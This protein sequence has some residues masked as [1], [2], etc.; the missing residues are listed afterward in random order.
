MP[1][2]HIIDIPDFSLVIMIGAAGAGKSSFAARHFAATEIIS[3]DTYRGIVSDDESNQEASR[4]AFELVHDIAAKRLKRRKLAVIDA[5]N[6][7]ADDRDALIDLAVK[8]HAPPV[9]LVINP[10]PETCFAQNAARTKRRV[11]DDVIAAQLQSLRGSLS[12]LDTEGFRVVHK[13]MSVSEI[14]N[15]DIKRIPVLADKRHLAGPFDIIGDVHGCCDELIALMSKLGYTV[16]MTKEGEVWKIVTQTPPGRTLVF[17]GDLVDRG[18]DTP[19]VLR[20]AMHMV[21]CGQALCVPGNHD[22][23]L[24]RWLRGNDV[25][26]THGLDKSATQ[27]ANEPD[28]WRPK[29]EK[30]V[31]DLPSHLWLDEGRLAVAHAGIKASLIGRVSRR[32]YMFCLYGE[33]S[34]ETDEFGLPIRYNWAAEYSGDTAIVYGHTPVP[35]ANWLNNTM[36][37]DT[38]CCFGGKLTALRW[39][40][41]E[42]VSV[43]A[44]AVY[45]EPIRPFGHPPAR[46]KAS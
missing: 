32:V 9:A 6:V 1:D 44:Q 41:K 33:T 15:T 37:L 35:E 36:C 7:R 5:T 23:K 12:Q 34:G 18:P 10:G 31:A 26:L 28:E 13:L 14:D 20:L 8:H 43:P 19:G 42:V 17:V 29:I 39:P 27:L 25:T 24:M 4:D 30:F 3:S 45:A 21:G 16:S 2:R 11:G 46:P 40:E 22:N 38:G